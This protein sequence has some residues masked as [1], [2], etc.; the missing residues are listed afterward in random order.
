MTQTT[1]M[2]CPQCGNTFT[3]Y[4]YKVGENY[5][6]QQ[7]CADRYA[8][9]EVVRL[10][11][12]LEHIRAATGGMARDLAGIALATNQTSWREKRKKVKHG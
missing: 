12:W 4:L 6:C 11:G 7:G 1:E 10:R 8:R 5:L 9:S 2:T 3:Q